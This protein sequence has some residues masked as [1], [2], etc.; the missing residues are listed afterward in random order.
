MTV[1]K[2][3]PVDLNVHPLSYVALFHEVSHTRF[4]PV[5]GAQ[6]SNFDRW[7]NHRWCRFHRAAPT[8]AR[9]Y[10]PVAVAS[11]TGGCGG[12]W[13]T[14]VSPSGRRRSRPPPQRK[15]LEN[16]HAVPNPPAGPGTPGW[17]RSRQPPAVSRLFRWFNYL[18]SRCNYHSWCIP[19]KQE[20]NFRENK[21]INL[22]DRKLKI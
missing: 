9:S 4:P 21:K 16:D 6:A 19:Y 18:Y 14:V 22:S 11:T 17:A 13:W 8:R 3:L 5:A 1:K 10:V 7:Y 20:I 12:L 15:V 2:N